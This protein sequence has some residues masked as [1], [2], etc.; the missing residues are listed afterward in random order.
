M[1]VTF[2][3]IADTAPSEDDKDALKSTMATHLELD[4]SSIKNF[5]VTVTVS[6]MQL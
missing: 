1:A 5:A 2:D 3:V 6:K 4:T